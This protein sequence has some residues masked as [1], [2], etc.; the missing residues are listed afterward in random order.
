MPR[1]LPS[2][3]AT[4]ALVSL[5]AGCGGGS[6]DGGGGGSAQAL[7]PGQ[8]IGMKSL[9]FSP[10][11]AQVPVGQEIVWHNDET[12]PHDVK[13]DSGADFASKTFGKGGTFAWTPSA[14]G[15][16]KYQC[17]LHPGMDGTIDVV[18]K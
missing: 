16:V 9:R 15:T 12:I 11:H 3:A 7:E 5:A 14:A 8:Q 4:L 6:D 10:E 13:A 2:L 17:T 18:A 1:R